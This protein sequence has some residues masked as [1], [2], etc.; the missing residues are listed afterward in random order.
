VCPQ[1]LQAPAE[2][3][4]SGV[5]RKSRAK[6]KGRRANLEGQER[7]SLKNC[8]SIKAL[9]HGWIKFI[10]YNYNENYNFW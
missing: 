5:E 2:K 3:A 1:V 7:T 10:K 4:G 9:R 8:Y 6:K